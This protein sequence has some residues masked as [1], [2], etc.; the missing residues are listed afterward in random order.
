MH[1]QFIRQHKRLPYEKPFMAPE[2]ESCIGSGDPHN[3]D[4]TSRVGRL[5]CLSVGFAL[6]S[7]TSPVLDSESGAEELTET[8]NSG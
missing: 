4:E 7:K 2:A 5:N 8:V 1:Y 3:L 6:A